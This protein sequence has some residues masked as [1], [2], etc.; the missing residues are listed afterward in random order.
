MSI[1]GAELAL[2]VLYADRPI[3][4]IQLVRVEGETKDYAP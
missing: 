3:L 4:M 1:F 2:K